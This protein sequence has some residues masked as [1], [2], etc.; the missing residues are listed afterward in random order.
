MKAGK[1]TAA[2]L[3]ILGRKRPHNRSQLPDTS[4]TLPITANWDTVEIERA[5]YGRDEYGRSKGAGLEGMWVAIVFGGSARAPCG[6]CI[7]AL[8]A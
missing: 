4:L 2:V 5:L 6:T 3:P 1:G 8:G 7:S